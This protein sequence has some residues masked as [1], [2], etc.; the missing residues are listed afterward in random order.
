MLAGI[1]QGLS[2]GGFD[3]VATEQADALKLQVSLKMQDAAKGLK[4]GEVVLTQFG[5]D[6]AVG[7]T[8]A[9]YTATLTNEPREATYNAMGEAAA[10]ANVGI[11]REWI[12]NK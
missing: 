4:K 10:T 9:A 2:R 6:S 1:S 8:G 5:A 12:A 11:L 7:N 3:V